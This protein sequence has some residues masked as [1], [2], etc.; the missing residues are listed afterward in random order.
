MHHNISLIT[1]IAAALGFGLI[2]G[3][4]A[5]RL[6]LPALVGY[7]AAGIVIGPATP[8]FVADMALASQLA[9]IGV[10]LL[11]FGVGLHFSLK[12]LLEVRGIALPGAVLQIAVA[13][14][15]GIGLAHLWG[16]SLG[17]GL[18]FGLALSVASTVVLLRALEDRG[19]LDSFNGR[20]AVGWLVVEDL[21][22]V[23]VLVL[24]PAISGSLGGTGAANEGGLLKALMLTLGQVAA[25]LAFMMLIGR[26][27]FPWFLWRVACTGSRE[28]F[29]LA[30]IATAVG[31]AY[32]SSELFGVSFALGAFFAG[33]VLRESE[34]SHR[35]A[36]ESLPLRDAFSVLFFVSVGMLLD[37]MVL[38]NS[39]WKVAAVVAVIMFG[40]SLA[41]FLLV[42]ALRYPLNTAITVSASLA[43]IGEFSFI[44]AALGL[45]L[46]LLPVEGQSLILAGAIISIA[47]NPLLFKAIAPLQRWLRS[48]SHLARKL[49]RSDDPLAQLPMTVEHEK[50]SGQVVLVGYGRVGRK[51][52]DA[53][54]ERG[55]HF[56]VAEQNRELV[57]ELRKRDIPAVAG[58][59]GEPAVLIQAH[60]ARASMLVIATPDTFQ[61]RS[62]IETAR[63]LNPGIQTVIRSHN[64]EEAELL[65]EETSGKIFLGEQELASS[66]AR[67]VLESL[68][69]LPKTSHD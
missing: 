38:V 22:T 4:L 47:L 9:E 20:V 2:F 57:E 29:T 27:L 8:G 66:M 46:G 58:N 42:I 67:H 6:K 28:L 13:T 32:G 35:A 30:V 37:P 62:M 44:L 25:F 10:M 21:V 48:K 18:V 23:L 17:A 12:D 41:A 3:M 16:W 31:I 61:V 56:V 1:T 60:I 52:A 39:P 11:M 19:I 14:A 40:K 15:M 26:K 43:Q 54:L 5:V 51:I 36:H 45:S 34:L 49:E 24:L 63:A 65:R 69:A 64:E 55:V 50:L 7:L 59:A 53:L 68:E 33:M